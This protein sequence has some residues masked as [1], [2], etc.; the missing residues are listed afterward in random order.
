MVS[1][2]ETD[3]TYKCSFCG[4]SQHDVKRMIAGPRGVFICNECVALCNE[5]IAEEERNK[6][7]S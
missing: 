1:G 7:Q 5:I 6:K 2:T 3:V 4:K